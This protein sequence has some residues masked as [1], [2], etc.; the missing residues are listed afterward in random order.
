LNHAISNEICCGLYSILCWCIRSCGFLKL[1]NNSFF[2][3]IIKQSINYVF[4]SIIHDCLSTFR[5]VCDP[6]LEEIR[7]FGRTETFEPILELSVVVEGN[8]A[9]CWK[10]RRR[11]DSP[12]GQGPGS[13]ADVEES[14]SRVPEWRH[15]EESLHVVGPGVFAGLLPPDGEV[16]DNNVQQ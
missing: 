3:P 4:S 2:T 7:R 12:M 5:Q 9:D 13:R 1:K 11:D 16:V 15:A 8:S 6:T 10:K 14:P